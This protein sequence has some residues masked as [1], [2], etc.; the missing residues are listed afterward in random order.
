MFARTRRPLSLGT[1]LLLV[2]LVGL[3][4]AAGPAAIANPAAAIASPGTIASPNPGAANPNPGATGPYR[5][6]IVR[7]AYGIPHITAANFGSLGYGFGYAFAT[8]DICTMAQDYITV[9]AQ[10]SHYFGPTA[11]YAVEANGTTINNLNSDIFWRGIADSGVIA[12]LLAVRSGPSAIGAQLRQLV[13][14]YAAGY[15]AYLASVGGSAGVSDPRCRGAAWV[16]P[17]TVFDAYLRIYQLVELASQDVVINAIASAAPPA[18]AVASGT[19]ATAPVGA[20]VTSPPGTVG[21]PP[22]PSSPYSASD[23]TPPASAAS[24]PAASPPPVRTPRSPGRSA[25]TRSRWAR[26]VPAARCTGCCSAT[27]TSP[28]TGPSGSTRPS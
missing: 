19:P 24:R 23:C 12:R 5:A 13:G 3:G 1:A 17:I 22:W 28:G 10:R 2:A 7:T 6:T 27:R 26:P 8:D 16:R 18:P 14:G 21:L 25:A 4:V 9:E 20:T 11:S 15:N